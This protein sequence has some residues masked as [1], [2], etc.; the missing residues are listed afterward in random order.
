MRHAQS[1]STKL[2]IAG[3]EKLEELV[4]DLPAIWQAKL[5][6]EEAVHQALS[7]LYYFHKDVDYLVRDEKVLIIDENTGRVMPDRSWERGL[8]QMIEIKEN[9]P[10][11]PQKETLAKISFQLF[12]RRYLHLSGMTGT[13]REVAR[14]VGDVYGLRVVRVAPNKKSQRIKYTSLILSD[15]EQRWDAAIKV[16]TELHEIGRPVLVGTR[17][18]KASEELSKRLSEVVI[19]HQLLNAKQDNEEAKIIAQA[20]EAGRITIATNMA[21]RGTDIILPVEVIENGGLHVLLIERNDNRRVDRQLAGRCARQGDPGSWQEI[22]SM[23]DTVLDGRKSS[24]KRCLQYLIEHYP[25]SR[26]SQLSVFWY[27][28]YV[29]IKREGQSRKIRRRLLKG[30]FGLR[31]SLSFSGLME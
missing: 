3:G 12:F 8:Q 14:E 13:C 2:T 26:I 17:S 6:R 20:G 7:A 19:P 24:L 18:V 16:I 15:E 1:G 31:K 5:R 25:D 23:Q 21:G 30:D 4:R 10:V 28:R 9:V 27:T 11:T 29:Q 22:I